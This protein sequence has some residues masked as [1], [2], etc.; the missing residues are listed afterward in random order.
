MSQHTPIQREVEGLKFTFTMMP[1]TRVMFWVNRALKPILSGIGV[2]GDT[3]ISKGLDADLPVGTALSTAI[4]KLE[5]Q[6][7]DDFMRELSE[8]CTHKELPL[9]ETFEAVFLGRPGAMY[10]WFI[11][12]VEVQFADFLPVLAR[13]IGG[14]G[15]K[16][17][18]K[19]ASL[20]QNT[21][22]G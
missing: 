17:K 21:S 8:H 7:L 18:A 9:K 20:S 12:A 15:D 16:A 2:L 5:P 22:T 13:R 10:A 6:M 19:V 3:A 4:E 11:A 14:L 1:P